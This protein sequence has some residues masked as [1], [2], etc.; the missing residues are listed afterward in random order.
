MQLAEFNRSLTHYGNK[1]V[2]KIKSW[3]DAFDQL[4]ILLEQSQLEKKII[5]IDEMPWM[6]SPRSSFLSALEHF[7]NGWASA[8]KDIL[9]IICGSATS[10]II[11][12]V[13]KNHGGL[14]NRVSV[15]IHLKPF[16][17]NASYMLKDYN[18][19]VNAKLIRMGYT[20]CCHYG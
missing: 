14:H 9:L 19:G 1:K 4:A 13:I 20:I 7:W 8:R 16:N 10:W 6:D 15:R 11:N 2:A 5:F 3:Y 17:M 12:K 18:D